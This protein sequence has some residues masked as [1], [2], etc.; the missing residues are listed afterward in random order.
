M[1]SRGNTKCVNKVKVT[2][3]GLILSAVDNQEEEVCLSGRAT[4]KELLHLLVERH[5]TEFSSSLL[6]HDWQLQP[7]AMIH[8]DGRDINEIDGANTKL[9]GDSQ[10]Y[11]TVL[12]PMITGG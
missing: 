6:T 5:G 4:V 11:I 12:A 2:Y 1:A 10:L 8:L 3:Y 7:L 9:E